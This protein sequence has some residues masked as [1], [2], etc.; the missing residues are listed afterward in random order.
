VGTRP[1]ELSTQQK[2]AVDSAYSAVWTNT[3]R[4]PA[5]R[6]P[7]SDTPTQDV[8]LQL[9]GKGGHAAQQSGNS[10]R[11][12]WSC[13]TGLWLAAELFAEISRAR[14]T[15]RACPVLPSTQAAANGRQLRHVLRGRTQRPDHARRRD[16]DGCLPAQAHDISR[17][18]GGTIW[19]QT[20][21]FPKIN[22]PL[23]WRPG[24][25]RVCDLPP[26]RL[27]IAI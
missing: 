10:S 2:L 14:A 19:D 25:D 11:A 7:G 23:S 18:T 6:Q 15:V 21:I 1:P 8:A 3:G 27:R 24:P 20:L 22:C 9:P 17:C 12:W 26:P 13:R 4:P 16:S 5:G